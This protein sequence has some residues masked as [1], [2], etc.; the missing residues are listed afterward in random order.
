[1]KKIRVY[2][3]NSYL[4]GG[5][6]IAAQRLF[7]SLEVYEDLDTR[8]YS[9]QHADDSRYF[10]FQGLVYPPF[11]RRVMNK[12]PLLADEK[13]K[14][15]KQ[16]PKFLEGRPEGLEMFDEPYRNQTVV[17]EPLPDIIHL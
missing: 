17:P 14:V 12:V 8:L 7:N 1:M 9:K 2:H 11:L 4:Y 3:F 13:C 6:S 10:R 5:A 15:S 16:F